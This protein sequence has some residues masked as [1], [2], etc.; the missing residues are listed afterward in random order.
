MSFP[1]FFAPSMALLAAL[2]LPIVLFYFLKLKRTRLEV[3]SLVLWQQV[4]ADHRVNAPFQKFKRNFLLLLQL[5]LLA[6]LVLAAMQP[7]RRAN[8]TGEQ[9]LPILIDCSASMD[10][11]DSQG[12]KTR[13][14]QAK[15]QVE[16]LIDGLLPNQELC[17]IRFARS[18]RRLTGFTNNKRLLKQA[19]AKIKI[20][21]VP[22]EL[23]DAMRIAEALSKTAPFE[24]VVLFSD[25]NFPTQTDFALP[26][27]IDYQRLDSPGTNVGITAMNASRVEGSGGGAGGG[28][29]VFIKVIAANGPVSTTLELWQDGKRLAVEDLHVDPKA[30]KRLVFHVTANQTSTLTAKLLP[31]D[32]DSLSS[33][34][35][36][37]LQISRT[38]KLLAYVAKPLI[39]ERLAISAMSEVQLVRR[40]QL[41]DGIDLLITDQADAPTHDAKV[42]M[43]VGTLPQ[44][45][46][47]LMEVEPLA[48]TSMVSSDRFAPVLSH[49]E[50]ADVTFLDQPKRKPDVREVD[51]EQHGYEILVHGT[52][53][54]ILLRKRTEQTREYV[55]PVHTSR[56]TLPYRVG[57]PVM[58]SNLVR[59]AMDMAGL[60]QIRASQTGVLPPM[61]LV[62]GKAYTLQR[63]DGSKKTIKASTTG[64]LDAIP[65]LRVGT[66]LIRNGGEVVASR[67]VGLL[68]AHETSLK[69]ERQIQFDELAVSAAVSP[70][71]TD[72]SFWPQIAWLALAVLI[73]EWWYFHRAR[74]SIRSGNL[75]ENITKKQ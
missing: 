71:E 75:N 8:V 46:T 48:G 52:H 42:I 21:D 31:D 27:E 9:R 28:W 1:G 7:Y 15:K 44:D 26:F 59:M 69:S 39:P 70:L 29:E 33:D 25:G 12:G 19:L 11:L 51:F 35:Q 47:S 2:A 68:N 60:Q 41:N 17:I 64:T 4:L 16:K 67:H 38:R 72:Q 57:F 62:S 20:Q 53:G 55:F 14:D 58:M 43:Y 23:T 49:V 61:N 13:L 32:F 6:L 18:A 22:G 74:R 54:P 65:A 37:S 73:F 3:A 34:N 24:K 40:A 56:T 50:M 63:P 36:V 30:A 66:Y 10:A 5:L 45:L